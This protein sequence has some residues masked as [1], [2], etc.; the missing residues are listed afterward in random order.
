M[1]ALDL[2]GRRGVLRIRWEL[3]SGTSLTFRALALAAD[4]PPATLN[5]RLKELRQAGLLAANGGYTITPLTR[6]LLDALRPF[7]RMV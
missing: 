4:L 6:E 3:R 5:M 7:D 2:F 1:A